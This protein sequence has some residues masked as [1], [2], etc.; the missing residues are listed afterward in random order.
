MIELAILAY[1]SIAIYRV[2]MRH[3]NNGCLGIIGLLMLVFLGEAVGGTVGFILFGSLSSFEAAS[4]AALLLAWP[5]GFVGFMVG[6][7][8][9]FRLASRPAESHA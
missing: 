9:A 1:L 8:L 6:A 3:G 2:S 7:V 4:E 5:L